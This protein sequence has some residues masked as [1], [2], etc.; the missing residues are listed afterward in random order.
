MPPNCQGSVGEMLVTGVWLLIIQN[1]ELSRNRDK[2][3]IISKCL[4]NEET[5][6]NYP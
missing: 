4:T 5:S 3:S 6:H 1:T 2:Y